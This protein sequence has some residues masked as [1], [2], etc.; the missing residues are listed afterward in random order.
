MESEIIDLPD[1]ET[2]KRPDFLKVIC[3]LSFIMCGLGLL[4][5]IY[6]MIQNTPEKMTE[7]IEKLKE[8]SPAMAD[9]LEEQ[10]TAMQESTY[11]QIAP[12]LNFIYILLSFLG[13]L[14]MWKLNKKGFY[15]YIAGEILPY[16]PMIFM[17]KETMAMMGTAGGGMA[18][19]IGMIT[20]VLMFVFDITFIIM[21]ALNL[22]HMKGEDMASS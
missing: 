15:L 11:V 8:I 14:M 16:I 9:Q 2:K 7:N 17:G 5:G 19:T 1:F 21:Y 6:N 12:Y 22:K 4:S 18:Q 3:I 10:L 13:V 20:I